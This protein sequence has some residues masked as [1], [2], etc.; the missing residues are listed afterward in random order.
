MCEAVGAHRAGNL[1]EMADLLQGLLVDRR[2]R[3]NRAAIL[4]DGGGHG[5]IAADALAAVGV[6]SQVLAEETQASLR[7]SLWQSSAVG[8]TPST[9]PARGTGTPGATR[10]RWQRCWPP[11]RSTGFS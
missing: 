6:D 11:T 4:T 3:M 9:W 1:T 7:A 8:P 2:M 5:A 10:V